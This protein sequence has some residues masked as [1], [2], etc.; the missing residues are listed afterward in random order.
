MPKTVD[1]LAGIKVTMVSCGWGHTAACTDAGDLWVFGIKDNGRLGLGEMKEQPT[2][3]K[4]VESLKAIGPATNVSCGDNHTAA[5]VGGKVYTWGMGSWGR[6][7]LGHQDDVWTP[8]QVEV[9][10]ET[11]AIEL[12]CGSYHTLFLAEEQNTVY[13]FGWNKNGR[14]GV[15]KEAGTSVLVPT[16]VPYISGD[17]TTVT[18]LECGTGMS[19]AVTDLGVFTWGAGIYGG[20]GHGTTEDEWHPK[21]L[22]GVEGVVRATCGSNH[23]LAVTKEGKCFAWGQ[24]NHGQ[25]GVPAEQK[26]VLVPTK[27]PLEGVQA[28]AAGKTH[29]L[30]STSTALYSWGRG[31]NGCLGHGDDN[32][33]STPTEVEDVEGTIVSMSASWV[34]TAVATGEGALFTFGNGQNHKLGYVAS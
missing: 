27:I 21:K 30:A 16:R 12:A 22:Q 20:H 14:V 23:C 13:G 7:G 18:S 5:I 24:N 11:T 15:G 1:L 4:T 33:Q 10:G 29:S 26:E 9:P 2:E 6:L 31:T 17:K 3:P 32:C 25:L 8:T 34:H 28:V 19:V